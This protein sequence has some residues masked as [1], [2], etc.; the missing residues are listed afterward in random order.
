MSVK[1]VCYGVRD[2]EVPFFEKLNNYGFK[3]ALV[4]ELMTAEN[5]ALTKDAQA[6][7]VRGNCKADRQN[8]K[9]MASYGVTYL[10]TRTVGLNHMDL[11]AAKEFGMQV[12]RVP[13]YSPNAIS[14]LAVTL[15]MMLIRHTAY[16]VNKTKSKDFTVN[17]TMLSKEI[18]HCI[19]GI[20]GT[21]KIGLT[22]A[23]LF[24]GLGAKVVAYDIF[25]NEA[26]KQI[27]DYLP[28]D[29][30]LKIADVVSVHVPYFKGQNDK[31]INAD[32]LAKMKNDAVLINTARGGLQDDEAILAA[33]ENH[34]LGAFGTDG[35]AGEVDLFFKNMKN[36]ALPYPAVEKLIN[37]YPR[38]LVTPHI[39][40]YTDEALTNMVEI[41]FA[42]LNE[43][44]TTGNCCNKVES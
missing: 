41:S 28:L 24:K 38:V 33:I 20:L 4:P 22:T 27:V 14:E 44:L 13:A 39:G 11:E 21:G 30:V 25:E 29:E 5:V 6:V 32:F 16:T 8:I 12:A 42:N 40:S 10:L 36:Q 18:R 31:M 3:L 17:A 9:K 23:K 43:F 19:V 7:I 26:A 1:V 37:Y 2:V 34:T 35:F 15:A